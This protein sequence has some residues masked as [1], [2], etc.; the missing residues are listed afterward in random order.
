MS[1]GE[2]SADEDSQGSEEE[3]NSTHTYDDR[4][5]ALKAEIL[6]LQKQIQIKEAEQQ[7]NQDVSSEKKQKEINDYEKQ[8][9]S[10]TRALE[11]EKK[12]Q[13]KYQAEIAKREG[14]MVNEQELIENS[15]DETVVSLRAQNEQFA[16]ELKALH[17]DIANEVGE[18]YDIDELLKNG[19]SERKRAEELQ[20][21]Q[22]EV[23][24][25]QGQAVDKKVKNSIDGAADRVSK[26]LN[27][28]I[29]QKAELEVKNEQMKVKIHKFRARVDSLEEESRAMRMMDVLLIEKLKH[30]AELIQH[31]EEYQENNQEQLELPCEETPPVTS[32][33]VEQLKNQQ[34]IVKGLCWKLSQ[35]QKELSNYTVPDSF[36]FLCEQLSTI[37]QR[38]IQLQK[39]LLKREA[40]ETEKIEMHIGDDDE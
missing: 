31:L 10:F 20:K 33:I 8:I 1:S 17:Q 12:R 6:Q 16:S 7:L 25:L 4:I 40:A 3:N 37:N 11:H 32:D 35:S 19:S 2:Y 30:D 21:L 23:S 14:R 34:N 36:E 24:K 18:G 38:C 5:R 22:A 9:S 26:G 27:D 39:T 29:Q 28:L 13:E 15:T